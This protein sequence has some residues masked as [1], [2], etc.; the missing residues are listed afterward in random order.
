MG[1]CYDL[2]A[3]TS[4]RWPRIS[5]C[6]RLTSR[7]WSLTP[8]RRSGPTPETGLIFGWPASTFWGASPANNKHREFMRGT[9]QALLKL[10]ALLEV[11]PVVPVPPN[12]TVEGHNLGDIT[13]AGHKWQEPG[14]GR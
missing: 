8:K 11:L 4:D 10:S 12:H 3:R 13:Q 7:A 1:S 5:K 2:G 9:D 14:A 6:A